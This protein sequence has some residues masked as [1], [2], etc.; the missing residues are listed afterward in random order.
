MKPH[1]PNKLY[2][3]LLAAFSA[4]AAFTLAAPPENYTLVVI[5]SANDLS[6]YSSR[7]NCAFLIESD[8]IAA[9]HMSGGAQYWS[10]DNPNTQRILTFSSI[11]SG[12][13]GAICSNTL[14]IEQ[15]KKILF[16]SC[17]STTS[18]TS[19][20]YVYG[21]GAIYNSSTSGII[22]ISRNGA[23]EFTKNHANYR[24][25][26]M[27][28]RNKIVLSGNDSLSFDSNYVS[29]SA[30]AARSVF[31]GA[32]YTTKALE[33]KSNNIVMFSGNMAYA[34]SSSSTAT[35]SGGAIYGE[36]K[37]NII[38][39]DNGSV[40]FNGNYTKSSSSSSASSSGGAICG[41]NN[42]NITL[43]NNESVT[44][45]GN[46]ASS[47]SSYPSSY[48][49]SSANGGAIYGGSSSIIK[50]N[51]NGSVTF[52]G[53]YTSSSGG[54]IYGASDSSLIISN[55]DAVAF[56]KNEATSTTAST[57]GG[58]IY[59]NTSSSI[60]LFEN[61]SVVF[62]G[63]AAQYGAA[64]FEKEICTFTQNDELQFIENSS[65]IAG[66]AIYGA[67]NSSLSINNNDA[68]AFRMNAAT[69]TTSSSY[70]GAIYGDTSG[71]I[72][73]LENKSVVFDGNSAQY[74]GAIYMAQTCSA[75]LNQNNELQFKE[76]SSREEG[77]AICGG[78][79]IELCDNGVITFSG[80]SS[81]SD[82][83]RSLSGGAIYGWRDCVLTLNN[84]DS[85]IFKENSISSSTTGANLRGGAICAATSENGSLTLN[86]NKAVSFEG[87]TARGFA[88]LSC[89]QGGA[90]CGDS[91]ITI[92]ENESVLFRAN[93]VSS[94]MLSS[95][96]GAIYG[97]PDSII[98]IQDNKSVIFVD[99][100]ADGIG[101]AI[102]AESTIDL[103][104]N[105]KVS[106]QNNGSSSY[107]GAIY[108]KYISLK[109]NNVLSFT[110]NYVATP[111]YTSHGGAI[112]GSS[113]GN[114]CVQGNGDVSFSGNWAST[115]SS[116]SSYGGAVTV[117]N[118]SSMSINENE[119]VIFKSNGASSTA[120]ISYAHGGA[121][122]AGENTS[123]ALNNNNN[124]LFCGNSVACL[125]S[126][127]D[128]YGAAIYSGSLSKLELRGNNH[129]EF[130]GN[131]EKEGRDN[132]ASF[133]LRSIYMIGCE[134]ALSAGEGQNI[135]FYD[136]LY[137]K[138]WSNT[139]TV[140]F[141]DDYVDANGISQKGNG[142]IVFSG[143]Y[144]MEDLASLKANYS[145]QE[146]QSSLTTEV[147]A[148][149]NVCGGCLRIE[150]G[151]IFR[152]YGI[153]LE[154]GSNASLS[155]SNGTL[156]VM[157]EGS[158]SQDAA[159]N[160]GDSYSISSKGDTSP[161]L[162][163]NLEIKEA[164][165]YGTGGKGA[166][167]DYSIIKLAEGTRV[168]M[169]NM[170]LGASSLLTDDTATVVANNLVIEGILDENVQEGG[171]M[172]IKG[173]SI[174][175]RLG[176]PS[177]F[178]ELDS[179]ACACRLDI[180]NVESV[181]I[182]GNS[183]TIDLSGMYSAL[184]DYSQKYEWLGISL[185]SGDQVAMLDTSMV[186]ELKLND[187]LDPH[188]YYLS[189]VGWGGADFVMPQYGENVGMVYFHFYEVPEPTTTTLS[190]LALAA[191]G[192]RRRRVR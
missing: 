140:T 104:A 181:N 53:N 170:V 161:A 152:S 2:A 55:N 1:L 123:I 19:T 143:K 38:L 30:S 149:T 50:L 157:N 33:V 145:Q 52:T 117:E 73:L 189:H 60:A 86:G 107:G 76:N 138:A 142:D 131:Y 121:I 48:S 35:S 18:D 75:T 166:R 46:Y 102:C 106:F 176:Q 43:S 91:A 42:C 95:F 173:G 13:G 57:Y 67:S 61:K 23:A 116:S 105:T 36:S 148:I 160:V 187:L 99:N 141:N 147:Y 120:T 14:T 155:L 65:D 69:T 122:S 119:N 185:G 144:A 20:A 83:T 32:I 128:A 89:S 28:S 151:A 109:A 92:N 11:S 68:V 129:V 125:F 9:T 26:A 154:A 47:S 24:G 162:S 41:E 132:L 136:T 183:L 184:L 165:V 113:S 137:A 62:N 6:Q 27:S 150:D 21:G 98:E 10:S 34:S 5:S 54:A 58:A 126:E 172:T 191:L 167:I 17:V 93:S 72:A 29:E 15:L 153:N 100:I 96:G 39:S 135:I 103:C 101:G 88:S 77:G 175:Q 108:G 112:C 188:A 16:T 158:F 169:N 82:S 115:T 146:L 186:V 124:V 56:T 78:C 51:T 85:I 111:S 70:G 59:G 79:K 178:V 182:T 159:V 139:L 110:E 81:S 97:A 22:D 71:S 127:S 49:Y 168:E 40:T 37:S 80:N 7:N 180:T 87:N 163:G 44:F 94:V 190:L 74:G 177:E 133:R 179:D 64:I 192:T 25:G 8:I 4:W 130:R 63:N 164:G 84:N 118:A 174:M 45:T 156:E 90:I 134:L 31:G 171:P 114:I 3:A 66:G 12:Y